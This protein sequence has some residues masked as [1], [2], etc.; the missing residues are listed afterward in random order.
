MWGI[1]SRLL[2]PATSNSYQNWL[3]ISGDVVRLYDQSFWKF[4]VGGNFFPGARGGG[5]WKSQFFS[6][7]L[8]EY[9]H[10]RYY[11]PPVILIRTDWKWL[12]MFSASISRVSEGLELVE[13]FFKGAKGGGMWKCQFFG[14]ELG[15]YQHGHY[16]QLPVILIGTDWKFLEMFSGSKSR[17]SEGL[18]WW[19][20]FFR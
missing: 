14:S 1:P 3:K 17:V 5:M 19:E 7:Q 15:E 6:S 12:E 16:Y 2:I 9:H 13:N 10:G 20:F 18:E 8:G 4:G 11:Q